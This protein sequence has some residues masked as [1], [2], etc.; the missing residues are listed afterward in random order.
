ML[1]VGFCE[2]ICQISYH[3]TEDHVSKTILEFDDRGVA[4]QYFF[5]RVEVKS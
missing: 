4:C 5:C 1:A 2:M 3:F